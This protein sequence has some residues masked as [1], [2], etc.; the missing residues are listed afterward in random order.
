MLEKDPNKRPTIQD[1]KCNTWLNQNKTP[2]SVYKPE[3]LS[4]SDD[5]VHHSLSFFSKFTLAVI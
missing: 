2:L 1:I 3:V 4:V 5:E